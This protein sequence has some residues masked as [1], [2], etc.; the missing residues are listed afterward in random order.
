ME[1][2]TVTTQVA[3]ES[4]ELGEGVTKFVTAMK[5]A[6]DDGW[7]AGE[8]L[9]PIMSSALSDLVP[10][11][12]GVEKIKDEPKTDPEA[13]SDACYLGMKK[14]PFLWVKGQPVAE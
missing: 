4:Y 7:Q 11:F 10:A 2:V 9:P 1:Y 14:I 12:Q 5:K 3:K 8:D 13:F 6:L